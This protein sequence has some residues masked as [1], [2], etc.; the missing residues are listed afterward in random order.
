MHAG[1]ASSVIWTHNVDRKF[2]ALPVA[3]LRHPFVYTPKQILAN[4]Y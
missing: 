3:P 4:I 2:K 1:F